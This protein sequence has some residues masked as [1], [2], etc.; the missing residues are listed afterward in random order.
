MHDER[1]SEKEELDKWMMM[2][3]MMMFVCLICMFV[4]L[5]AR[6]NLLFIISL[7][8]DGV[9]ND[10]RSLSRKRSQGFHDNNFT[11]ETNETRNF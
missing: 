9:S 6:E 10:S 5:W 1:K 8:S 7:V 3:T 4:R 2:M 11:L